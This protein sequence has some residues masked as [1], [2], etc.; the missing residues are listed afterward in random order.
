MAQRQTNLRFNAVIL[1][2]DRAS[3]DPVATVS[4]ACCKAAAPIDGVPMVMRVL[5]ELEASAYLHEGVLCG[6]PG[7]VIVG[8]DWFEQVL[9]TGRWRWTEPGPGPTASAHRGLQI[10]SDDLPA[11]IT[12]ADHALLNAS[13]VEYFCEHAARSDADI[14]VGLARHEA[15]TKAFPG[16]RKTVLRLRDGNYC[17]CNLFAIMSPHA[18]LALMQWQ[19][20]EQQRKRP[21]RI[22]ALVGWRTVLRYL[23]RSLTLAGALSG[24]SHQLGVRVGA[25]VLPFPEAA[26]DVD[27]EEDLRFVEQIMRERTPPAGPEARHPHAG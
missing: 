22:A 27:S 9:E 25:V 19:R 6:P 10:L 4:G 7:D 8:L 3:D 17:G 1:A 21:W 24:L 16:L 14:L 20:V 23:T 26:I 2:G 11:L 15:V 18:R 13:I 12:T 5:R